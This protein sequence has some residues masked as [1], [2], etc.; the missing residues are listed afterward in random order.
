MMTSQATSDPHAVARAI[1]LRQLDRAPKTRQQL[2]MA[3]AK[4]HV[5][6]TVACE[7]LDQLTVAGLIDDAA[8]ASMFVHSRTTTKGMARR[9]LRAALVTRGCEPAAIASALAQLNDTQ[10]LEIA[11]RLVERRQSRLAGLDRHVRYRRLSG[12]L[13]RRGHNASVIAQALADLD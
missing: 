6:A 3:L 5:P 10:E 13:A 2:E 12:M 9:A 1:A 4:R 11:K 7:V 8:Y